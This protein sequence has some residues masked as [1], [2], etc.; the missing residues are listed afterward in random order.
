MIYL[1]GS[2]PAVKAILLRNYGANLTVLIGLLAVVTLAVYAV[3]VARDRRPPASA[4]PG[5]ET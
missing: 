1:R 5:H 4:E 3:R 2:Q